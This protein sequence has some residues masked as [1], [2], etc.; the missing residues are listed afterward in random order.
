[1]T[2]AGRHLFV[3][4]QNVRAS[5]DCLALPFLHSPDSL[6][7]FHAGDLQRHIGRLRGCLGSFSLR[8]LIGDTFIASAPH[9]PSGLPLL[10]A[11]FVWMCLLRFPHRRQS[12]GPV[13]KPAMVSRLRSLTIR[14]HRVLPSSPP[15][16][17]QLISVVLRMNAFSYLLCWEFIPGLLGAGDGAPSMK[18]HGSRPATSTS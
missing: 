5:R 10:G 1:M 12:G 17:P 2:S 18:W 6:Q 13:R 4:L 14:A 16:W 7:D 9:L 3:A 15:F 11:H 8:W